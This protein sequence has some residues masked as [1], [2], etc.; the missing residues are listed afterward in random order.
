MAL[1]EFQDSSRS[2]FHM[3]GN[4]GGRTYSEEF[5]RGY[6]SLD[7]TELRPTG[8]VLTSE[9]PVALAEAAYNKL[10][11]AGQTMFITQGSTTGIYAAL[12][13]ACKPG[14]KLYLPRTV[15][16]S[17]IRAAALLDLELAFLPLQEA[18]LALPIVDQANSLHLLEKACNPKVLLC[19]PDYY[20]RC[21][22]IEKFAEVC[23][24]R[25]GLLIVDE[26]HGAHLAAGF[27]FLPK[28]SLRQGADIVVSS[29][30]KTLPAL[31]GAAV[32]QLNERITAEFNE[33]ARQALKLFHSTSPSFPIAASSDWAR[34]YLELGEERLKRLL[35]AIEYL[36]ENLPDNFSLYEAPLDLDPLHLLIC[37]DSYVRPATV[38]NC[39][40]QKRIYAEMF[41]LNNFLCLLSVATEP[42]SLKL[43]AAELAKIE[44]DNDQELAGLETALK[45]AYLCEPQIE[46]SVR[47][48]LLVRAKE[49]R[50]LP[51]K[52]LVGRVSM[53]IVAPYPPGLALLYPGQLIKKEHIQ[54]IEDLL[55][56]G[57]E[58][59]G[60]LDGKVKALVD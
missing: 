10:S 55:A 9:G 3:P 20:G 27:D 38:E 7:T 14:E 41:G 33:A 50:L 22:D 1:K 24:D 60:V 13:T 42:D 29:L 32:L 35:E 19:S 48:A 21:L 26:A 18:D 39:L 36:R 43:L 46:I 45:S 37:F 16:F 23:H 34:A 53:D 4:L 2:I 31:T 17:I 6:A 40:G 56:A 8:N 12:A 54:L 11:G 5:A 49:A 51:L 25:S 52:E 44:L 15:H 57:F 30:H 58:L 59:S 47:E 28:S